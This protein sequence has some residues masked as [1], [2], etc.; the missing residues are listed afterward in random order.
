MWSTWTCAL[1]CKNAYISSIFSHVQTSTGGEKTFE[2]PP[3]GNSTSPNIGVFGLFSR[4]HCDFHCCHVKPLP[5]VFRYPPSLLSVV[6]L[7]LDSPML[8]GYCTGSR[9]V[10]I[11]WRRVAR[12]TD[13]VRQ[14]KKS[15]KTEKNK[16]VSS[17]L[18][19]K[20]KVAILAPFALHFS[21][22][23]RTR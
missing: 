14:G 15:P 10:A 8:G 20:G 16:K 13:C 17:H 4:I 23:T 12:V 18:P 19:G 11:F 5:P 7:L 3:G 2:F 22:A 9:I 6:H 21:N 1:F